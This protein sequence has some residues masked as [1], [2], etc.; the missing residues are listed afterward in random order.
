[1]KDAPPAVANDARPREFLDL[2]R[3]RWLF[4]E[5]GPVILMYHKV[6]F[7]P[8]ASNLPALYVGRRRFRQQMEALDA[9]GLPCLTMGETLDAVRA[10][11]AG[12][13]VTFDDGFCNVFDHALPVL[14]ARGLRSIQFIVAGL[15]GRDDA[16]DRAIGE[17]AQPLMDDAQIR[18]WLAA[19]QEIGAHTLT[20]PRLTQIPPER[21]RAEIFDSKKRLEDR[22]GGPIKYFCYPYGD[23]DERVRDMVAEAGYE[24]ATSTACGAN[25]PETHPHELRRIMAFD[26]PAS[27]GRLAQRTLHK[28]WEKYAGASRSRAHL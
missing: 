24:G 13:C 22:F 12:Y 6:A 9:S 28:A 2:R 11:R 5:G 15:I 21:A 1:M 19:G 7:P 10:G 25:H 3:D 16:W 18:D 4:E 23:C 27:F 17:P 14:S 20:H 8:L 26:D